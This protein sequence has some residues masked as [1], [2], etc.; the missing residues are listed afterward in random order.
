MTTQ[1]KEEIKKIIIDSEN[2][3]L[4]AEES[5][6]ESVSS[7]V[8]LFYTLKEL[9]KNVN[10]IIEKF[11]EKLNFLIP[12]ID[13]VSYPKNFII[14]IPKK[15]AEIS[16]IYYEKNDES[17]KV[18]LTIEKGTV[19][20]DDISFYFS[21]T[22]P[23]IIITL[24]IKDYQDLL[25][26]KLNPFGFLLGASVLN[27]DS[28]NSSQDNKNFGKINLIDKMSLTEIIIG[29]IAYIK[30]G[31][32]NKESASCLLAGLVAYTDNFKGDKITAD[33][34]E[35]A[36]FLIKNGADLKTINENLRI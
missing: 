18:H 3:C 6:L 7:A 12:S 20:K 28:E 15:I 30:N 11:P 8:A 4:I 26:T 21:E 25:E 5:D 2:I 17:L 10:L 33:I 19:K 24:K 13:F 23:D 22:K 14:S 32:I 34:F 16:Q 35:A 27:I 31:N 29:I 1:Q 36:A 9:G